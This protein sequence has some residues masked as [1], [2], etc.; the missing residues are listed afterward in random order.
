MPRRSRRSRLRPGGL[1]PDERWFL[2]YGAS[3]NPF[4]SIDA[5]RTAWLKHRGELLAAKLPTQQPYF[6]EQEFDGARR[7][8]ESAADFEQRKARGPLE[9]EYFERRRLG[10]AAPED[11]QTWRNVRLAR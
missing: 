7:V 6:A 11:F 9:G 8:Y 5:A 10:L 3:E 4:P 2:L 1:T